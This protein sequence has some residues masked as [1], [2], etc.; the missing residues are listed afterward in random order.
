MQIQLEVV[1]LDEAVAF[2][3]NR[4][5]WL[6]WQYIPWGGNPADRAREDWLA[7]ERWLCDHKS[8]GF[9]IYQEYARQ[10]LDSLTTGGPPIL[11][12]N[13][14]GSMVWEA[15]IALCYRW[16]FYLH[17]MHGKCSMMHG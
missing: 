15:F 6:I 1:T 11:L 9:G 8:F 5:A 12:E 16:S 13:I 10:A 14:A 17:P 4:L 7:A 2:A 3:Q